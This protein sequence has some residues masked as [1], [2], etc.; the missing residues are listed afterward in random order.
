[1]SIIDKPVKAY[2]VTVSQTL[3]KTVTVLTNDY[4][5]LDG[6][7]EKTNKHILVDD[8]SDTNWKKVFEREHWNIASLLEVLKEY[9]K[10]DMLNHTTDRGQR[11]L[12][13]LFMACNNW[14][15]D[16]YEVIKE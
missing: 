14:H 3:S 12:E 15:E 11:Q 6:Y 7:D 10:N 16:E 4:K 13:A 1:M 2:T 9:V 8:T 5:T